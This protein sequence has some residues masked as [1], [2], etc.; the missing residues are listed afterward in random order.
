[1]LF[2]YGVRSTHLK[3]SPLENNQ[4]QCQHCHNSSMQMSIFGRYAHLFWIPLFSIGKTGVSQCSHCKQTLRKREFSS[5][6]KSEYQK[7]KATAK[8]PFWYFSGLIL[9]GLLFILPLL[10]SIIVHTA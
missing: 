3:T 6:L 2:F 1:M 5:Q 9:I 10:I 8:I 4:I 7:I